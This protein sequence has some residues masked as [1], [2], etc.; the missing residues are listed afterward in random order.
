MLTLH[1]FITQ[2]RIFATLKKANKSHLEVHILFKG[3]FCASQVFKNCGVAWHLLTSRAYHSSVCRQLSP[4]VYFYWWLIFTFVKSIW[5][6]RKK[7]IFCTMWI[8]DSEWLTYIHMCVYKCT[9]PYVLCTSFASLVY[10]L[11]LKLPCPAALS[12][13]FIGGWGR[14][15]VANVV[16]STW[17]QPT[18]YAFE[19]IIY[20]I[21]MVPV[22]HR[23]LLWN[24]T[25]MKR[26]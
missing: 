21:Y 26:S 24:I 7:L 25:E 14:M 20:F 2:I 15:L 22:S 9:L 16:L 19:M 13:R 17:E 1:L 18:G 8:C 6:K 10:K 12:I 3:Y 11:V 5:L 23:S 4:L